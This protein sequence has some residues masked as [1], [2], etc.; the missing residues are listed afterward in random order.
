MAKGHGK[1]VEKERRRTTDY[2]I[3]KE[4]GQSEGKRAEEG[5]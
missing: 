1:E 5:K 4:R 2:C 3:R